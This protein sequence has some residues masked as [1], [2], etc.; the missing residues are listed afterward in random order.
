MALAVD[1]EMASQVG[2]SG[3]TSTTLTYSFT[4]TAGTY[5]IVG[6]A[7]CADAANPTVSGI[8]YGGTAM[9]KIDNQVY[10]SSVD[11]ALFK[12]ASPATGANNVVVTVTTTAAIMSGAT[13]FTG[14]HATTPVGTAAKASGTS[15]TPSVDVTSTTSGNIVVD[16]AASGSAFS[17]TGAGQ[18]LG[19]VININNLASGNNGQ[20]SREPG[21]GGTVT[22]SETCGSDSWGIVAVE[23]KAAGGGGT[24]SVGTASLP[25]S[26]VQ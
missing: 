22:M 6:A 26:G 25:V 20:G 10:G 13:S 12:L 3:T 7:T 8:T 11:V 17:A 18:T 4:N 23:V 21:N 1:S 14:E 5:L 19:W 15:T 16:V 24:A 9:T 2:A